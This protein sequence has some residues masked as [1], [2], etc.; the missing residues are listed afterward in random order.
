MAI[1]HQELLERFERN[2][3][4]V[5][6]LVLK[7]VENQSVLGLEILKRC[8]RKNGHAHIIGITGPPGAGKST[9]VGELCKG[10]ANESLDIAVVC[11]DPSSPFSGGALL[12][13]RVRMMELM[14]HTN[15]FIKSL[16][17]RGNLG[18][19]AACTA[20]I[21]RTLDAA[22]K[23][24]IVVETVGVGQVEFD[25]LDVSDTVILVTVPGLGDSIQ[26]LKAGI[27]EI[28]DLFV[29]NQAD[30]PGADQTRKDIQMMLRESNTVDWLPSVTKTVATQKQGIDELIREIE[31]HE[32]YLRNSQRWLDKRQDRNIKRFKVALE[33]AISERVNVYMRT[34][35][36]VKT[37][38]QSVKE[39]SEDPLAAAIAVLD[40]ALTRIIK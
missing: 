10:W 3:P 21:V 14:K 8:G 27:M 25:V 17:T 30:R 34:D 31:R 9:L 1:E 23:D 11:I 24:I 32:Q 15:V 37:V 35:P 13:D 28:A 18:G 22:G 5:L 7:E 20:D 33:G 2:D 26:A 29:V 12:G 36:E 16:A 38:L 6:G 40:V 4:I 19:M 39:G